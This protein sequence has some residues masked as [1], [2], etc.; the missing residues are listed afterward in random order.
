MPPYKARS[1]VLAFQS[2]QPGTFPSH[3]HIHKIDPYIWDDTRIVLVTA[4]YGQYS[5]HG[6]ASGTT[7]CY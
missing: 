7:D 1:Y 3:A 6:V 5:A 2:N 4:S